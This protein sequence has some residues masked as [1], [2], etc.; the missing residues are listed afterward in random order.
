MAFILLRVAS[1]LPLGAVLSQLNVTYDQTQPPDPYNPNSPHVTISM[2]GDVFKDDPNEEVK[3]VN[4]IYSDIK[5]DKELNPRF[6]KNVTISLNLEESNNQ[7]VT[8]FKIN[9]S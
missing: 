5:S 9:C 2:A 8:G 1:H 3:V 4:Q 6:F 7:Q